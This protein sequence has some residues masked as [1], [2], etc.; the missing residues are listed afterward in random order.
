VNVSA[1]RT[2]RLATAVI[3]T[4]SAALVLL[5]LWFVG[6]LLWRGGR[7]IDW[8]FLTAGERINAPGSGIGAQIFNS[9]YF[10]VLAM[11]I[12]LPLGVLSGIFMAEYL[13]PGRFATALQL[14]TEALAS[15]PSIVV[16]L[17]GLLIFVQKAGWGY[18]LL[19]GALA[20]A[21]LNVPVLARI[22]DVALRSAPHELREA[23]YGL[24]ATKWQTVAR[25]LLPASLPAL[26]S[27]TILTAGR[28]F[29]EAAALIYTAGLTTPAL[30]FD[31]WNPFDPHS[32]LSPMR[33]A[34]TL[35]VHVWK[36]NSEG[37]LPDRTRIAD[38]SAAVLIAAALLF[39]LTA[40]LLGRWVQRRMTAAR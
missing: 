33:P 15:L 17:F 36:L 35:A 34:E 37:L 20:V 16:G 25:V 14:S 26:V 22:T 30:R 1:R 3:W 21:L 39:N 27:G 23:S 32:F 13:P 11:A 10:L 9:A 2:D 5:L 8:H 29:G 24:G 7:V 40:R 12:S 6:Y 28:V 19:G 31:N 38:G 18:T 4:I